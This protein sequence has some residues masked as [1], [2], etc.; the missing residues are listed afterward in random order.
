MTQ[1][2]ELVSVIPPDGPEQCIFCGSAHQDE[3]PAD[4]HTFNRD[5]SKLKRDGRTFCKESR[6]AYYPGEAM[7]P[8]VE[9][10]QD[11]GK[12]GGYKAAAHHCIALK[13]A[14]KHK[15]SG[16][17]KEAGYDPNRGE[18]CCWLPYSQVQFSRARAYQ[19]PLQKH[20]GGHTDAYF[21]KV[22]EHL[23]RVAKLVAGKFC[24][25]N[26]KASAEVLLMFLGAQEKSIW[27]GLA[28]PHMGAYHLYN[29]SYLDPMA[30]WGTFDPEM[31]KTPQ[32]VIKA[33]SPP[34]DDVAAEAASTDDP[35]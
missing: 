33:G 35:E 19:K 1:L 3:K 11:I 8:L 20:R 24:M 23:D 27:S 13:C 15:L 21:E 2:G 22:D 32:D 28:T 30:P 16:E 17:L 18:N 4:A 6:S 7:A 5:M 29:Q 10:E 31:G 9:W 25:A 26:L 12:T 14:S 34:L